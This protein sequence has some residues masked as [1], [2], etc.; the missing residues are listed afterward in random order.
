MAGFGL[1]AAL[2]HGTWLRRSGDFPECRIGLFA[3]SK[4]AVVEDRQLPRQER[5]TLTALAVMAVAAR[6]GLQPQE[7]SVQRVSVCT[8]PR[9]AT[10]VPLWMARTAAAAASCE[11]DNLHCVGS[12]P[13]RAR[14][15]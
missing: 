12:G 6:S 15:D 9:L 2:R 3:G 7:T 13:S 10:F 11:R 4:V 1:K 8:A 5:A 14:C